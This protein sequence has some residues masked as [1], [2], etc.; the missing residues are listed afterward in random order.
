MK[1]GAVCGCNIAIKDIIEYI[2]H[3]DVQQSNT[4]SYAFDKVD[5][6]SA[7]WL[8]NFNKKIIPIK[9]KVTVFK[10]SLHDCS[11]TMCYSCSYN[12]ILMLPLY[13]RPPLIIK[14]KLH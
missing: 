8:C 10:K 7:F 3:L 14:L 1:T 5:N 4:K 9:Y 11:N 6:S 12:T 2:K 13:R